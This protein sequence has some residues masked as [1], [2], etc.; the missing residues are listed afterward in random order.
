MG[1]RGRPYRTVILAGFEILIGRGDEENEHL[2]F[3][4]AA[5]AD[6]WLH[7]AG[8]TPGSHVVIR[9]PEKLQALPP[10]VVVRAAGLAAWYS[11]ARRLA[12]WSFGVG[13][14]SVS[15]RSVATRAAGRRG[16]PHS[17]VTR[18]ISAPRRGGRATP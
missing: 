17:I 4:I 8:G 10:P 1:S 9:N 5:P 7:V 3:N 6:F 18:R 16:L 11:K 15:D 14:G 2:T 13:G 12:R